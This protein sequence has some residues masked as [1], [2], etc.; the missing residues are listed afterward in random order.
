MTLREARVLFT[1]F[2][3]Q[4]VAKMFCDGYEAAWD[5]VTERI[6]PKDPT[7]DH[8]KGSLH[9]NGLA[10][11]V[12]LY[13]DGVYLTK[14]EDHTAFGEYWES[15]HPHCKWGGHFRDGNHY[16]FAPPEIVGTRK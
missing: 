15:L 11:D 2:S 3:V 7:S 6:T 9:H 8:M 5:E 4:L 13:K 12:L 14:T 1:K 10:A 16:S